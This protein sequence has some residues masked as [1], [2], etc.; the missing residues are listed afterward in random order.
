VAG[1][2]GVVLLA[3]LVLVAVFAPLLAP[4]SASHIDPARVLK[5][6][7]GGH[8]LGSDELG[9]DILSRVLYGFRVT[10]AVAVGAVAL[11]FALALPVGLV[12]GMRPGWP[13]HLLMR[14]IDMLLAMPAL[15]L[16]LVAVAI[17]GPGTWVSLFAIALV[18]LPVFSRLIRSS[19]LRV[20]EEPFVAASHARGA[21]SIRVV[22]W[23]VLPN[24]IGP[25]VAQATVLAGFAIQL[26][27]ALSFLGLGTLPPTPSLGGMLAEGRDFLQQAPWI[28]LFP[29]LAVVLAVLAFNLVGDAL[30]TSLD[31]RRRSG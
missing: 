15:V 3:L 17:A 23:H 11:A 25:A 2:V 13:D 27:A 14:P 24:A 5:G 19:V 30:R 8:L 4:D 20:R 16:A 26:E 21:S 31:P 18:Y 28:E 22:A 29:G 6:P 7:G 1:R 9:R 12:A 10:L